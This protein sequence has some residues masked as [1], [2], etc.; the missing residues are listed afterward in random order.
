MIHPSQQVAATTNPEIDME[1]QTEKSAAYWSG[2]EAMIEKIN[3]M[4]WESA[5]NEYNISV[6]PGKL[7]TGSKEGLEY[8]HGEFQALVNKMD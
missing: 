1:L 8:A 4:G 6:P 5:R 2:Y 7:W 3:A